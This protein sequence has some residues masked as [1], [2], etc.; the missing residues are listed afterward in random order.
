M[1]D[2][3]AGDQFLPVHCGKK[4]INQLKESVSAVITQETARDGNTDL[5]ENRSSKKSYA[6]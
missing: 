4:L 3:P 6:N 5:T 1:S 2:G